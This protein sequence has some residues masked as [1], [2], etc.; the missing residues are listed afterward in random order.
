MSA[1]G[2]SAIDWR[3]YSPSRVVGGRRYLMVRVGEGERLEVECVVE[4]KNSHKHDVGIT[5]LQSCRH[6]KGSCYAFVL[7][8]IW[9]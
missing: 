5:L 8:N 4:H 6:E 3:Q 2:H 9:I 7:K 1:E